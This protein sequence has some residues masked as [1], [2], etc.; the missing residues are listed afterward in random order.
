MDRFLDILIIGLSSG[1]IYA[2]VALGYTMVYGIV[3]LINFAHGDVIMVGAFVIYALVAHTG[4]PFYVAIPVSMAFCA[5]LGVAMDKIAYKPLRKASRLSA[6][7][8]AIGASLLLQNF[9]LVFIGPGPYPFPAPEFPP[10]IHLGGTL[11][12]AYRDILILGTTLVIMALL[13]LFVK[14][15]RMGK[16]MRAVSEDAG[17]A[18]LMGI[19]VNATISI[20]FAVG[21][22]LAAVGAFLHAS[23]FPQVEPFMGMNLGLNAFVAAVLGGIGSIPG[24]MLGGFLLGIIESFTRGYISSGWSDAIVFSILIV[25]LLLKPSGL[26]GKATGE[27]V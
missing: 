12:I 18:S 4:M 15:T 17:A 3:K 5:A 13:Q 19:N 24:A 16:A 25:V 8:T 9:V 11:T 22:A 7:I 26:L 14:R 20:T 21:S 1:S 27:K 2:L 23:S 10:N 6:L